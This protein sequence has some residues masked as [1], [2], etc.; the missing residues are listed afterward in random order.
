MDT[1][2]GKYWLV[3]PHLWLAVITV[4]LTA[5]GFIVSWIDGGYRER[6]GRITPEYE[7]LIASAGIVLLASLLAAVAV[8]IWKG[9]ARMAGRS[10]RF[11]VAYAIG[12]WLG[13]AVVAVAL[14]GALIAANFHLFEGQY[15]GVKAKA[16][17]G[18]RTA[19]L[20]SGGLFCGYDVYV[21]KGGESKVTRLSGFTADCNDL[22]ANPRL[23]WSAD[24]TSVDV[25]GRDGKPVPSKPVNIFPVGN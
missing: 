20:Y 23:V 1:P 17:S 24:S 12:A 25:V 4:A 7:W 14:A 15:L 22:P 16:P 18:D 8:L 11:K 9:R 19:Y 6:G 13:Q 3:R 5:P 10:T 21:R 2:R